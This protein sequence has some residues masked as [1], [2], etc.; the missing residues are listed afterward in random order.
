VLLTRSF[1]K[2]AKKDRLQNYFLMRGAVAERV[3]NMR[4]G[5]GG[6]LQRIG[7]GGMTF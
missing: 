1:K 5:D 7:G 2:S 3:L 6:A 4:D